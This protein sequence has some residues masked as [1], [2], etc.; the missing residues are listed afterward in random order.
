MQEQ[1]NYSLNGSLKQGSDDNTNGRT[2]TLIE[3]HLS[4]EQKRPKHCST[5]IGATPNYDE[6][7]IYHS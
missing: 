1:P 5:I 3:E 6:K 2:K 7:Q 4:D